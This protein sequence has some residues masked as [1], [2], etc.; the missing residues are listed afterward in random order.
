MSE[1]K[2]LMQEM[3]EAYA[4]GGLEEAEIAEYEAYLQEDI[5][6][7]LRVA[8]LRDTVGLLASTAAP[9]SPPTGMK[10]RILANV[11]KGSESTSD[12]S[13]GNPDTPVGQPIEEPKPADVSGEPAKRQ[14]EIETGGTAQSGDPRLEDGGTELLLEQARQGIEAGEAR[15]AAEAIG[16]AA[17]AANE[18]V[19]RRSEA[20]GSPAGDFAQTQSGAEARGTDAGIED[21]RQARAATRARSGR[22][23][24]AGAAAVMAAAAILLG[25]YSAQLRGELND[26]H[27]DM[28]AM[29]QQLDSVKEPTVGAEVD[30]TVALAGMEDDP[31]A[32]GTASMVRDDTGT[33]LLVQAAELPEL[34]GSQAYQVWLIDKE[35]NPINAGTFM[36]KSG[37][38]ALSYT[39]QPG[40]YEMVAIT[41][42]PDAEGDQPRGR[43]VLV[44]ALNG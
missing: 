25:V 40:D 23:L 34:S 41:L 35:G 36:S 1:R 38:G 27:A 33:H 2:E 12:A 10:S 22:A 20:N 30:R 24:W 16:N 37:S 43:K 44:G 7:R 11:L 42:E 13:K 19:P 4:L 9:V 29:Q 21:V 15:R 8:A 32:W 26:M 39:M 14:G 18:E 3:A 6:E 5:D 17:E 31:Q 28:T